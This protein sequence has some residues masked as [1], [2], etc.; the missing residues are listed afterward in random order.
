MESIKKI[1]FLAIPAIV[2]AVIIW[3]ITSRPAQAEETEPVQEAI[4]EEEDDE[5]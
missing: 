4:V 2:L 3:G 5:R 1:G